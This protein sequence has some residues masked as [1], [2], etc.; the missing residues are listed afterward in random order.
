MRGVDFQ[1]G[2][3]VNIRQIFAMSGGF[4]L[5]YVLITITNRPQIAPNVGIS[6]SAAASP[7]IPSDGAQPENSR[8][9]GY[10]VLPLEGKSMDAPESV[11]RFSAMVRAGAAWVV[12]RPVLLQSHGWSDELDEGADLQEWTRT[13]QSAHAANLRVLLRPLVVPRD[14]SSREAIE[15]RNPGI[16]FESYTRALDPYVKMAARE[17]V[18]VFCLGSNLSRLQTESAW[19]DLIRTVRRSYRGQLTYAATWDAGRSF[20]QAAF[21]QELDYV[22]I[23]AFVPLSTAPDPTTEELATAWQ[24]V[25]EGLDVWQTQ[26]AGPPVLFT[27]LG[28]PALRGAAAGPLDTDS[29]AG[30]DLALPV[31]VA[32]GFYRVMEGKNWFAGALWHMWSGGSTR[33]APFVIEGRPLENF[34]QTSFQRPADG[35]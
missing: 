28:Y 18:A 12:L 6:E 5:V 23:D 20:Q 22:G 29:G 3:P 24:Q 4:L 19:T 15:P 34:L 13:V 31:R 8:V 30:E 32:E 26:R 10:S 16:W 21:W 9:H 2:C 17:N 33:Q 11:A 25:G 1:G 35:R 14:G 27:A 7:A